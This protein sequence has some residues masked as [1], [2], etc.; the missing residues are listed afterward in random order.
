MTMFHMINRRINK[1]SEDTVI[2]W[3]KEVMDQMEAVNEQ[4]EATDIEDVTR[5]MYLLDQ[6]NDLELCL[7]I[8]NER[9]EELIEDRVDALMDLIHYFAE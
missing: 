4:L 7:E 6:Q 3:T 5:V 8:L 1:M 2:N 9:L